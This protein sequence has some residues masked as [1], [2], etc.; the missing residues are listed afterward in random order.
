MIS[1]IRRLIHSKIGLGIAFILIALAAIAFAA[2][3]ITGGGG[4]LGSFTGNSGV[5]AKVGGTKLTSADLQNRTQMVFDRNRQQQPEMQ[6][7]GFLGMGGLENVLDQLIASLAFDEFARDQGMANSKRLIDG[8]I[9]SIDAFKDASGNFSEQMYHELLQRQRITD[10][11]LRQDIGRDL[12]NRQILTPVS[13]GSHM[14]R[15][16]VLPYAS[17]LMEARQGRI[18]VVPSR[19][20]LGA[21]A[22]NPQELAEF[23]RR[24]ADRYT[25]PEQRQLRYVLVEKA[26]FDKAAAPT[27]AEIQRYYTE[28]K[29][30]YAA[31]EQRTLEQLILPTEAAA[32]TIEAKVKGGTALVEAARSA[33]L[34]VATL[35]DLSQQQYAERSSQAVA[36]S[37]FA[38][39][40]GQIAPLAKSPLGWHLVRVAAVK[41][42]PA[43]ALDAVRAEVADALRQQKA[44]EAMSDFLAKAEDQ[45]T[46]GVTFDEFAKDSNLPVKATPLIVRSGVAPETP[47]YKAPPEVQPLLQSAFSMELD[48]E[49]QMVTIQPDILYALVDVTEIKPAAP[50]PLEKVRELVVQQ[51]QLDRA[52]ARAKTT[53]EQIVAKVNK[54]TDL[55]KAIGESGLKIPPPE[56]LG[57][58]RADI[59]RGGQQV[60][61]PLAMLFSM[62]EGSTKTLSAGNDQGWFIVRL[63]RIQRGD[64]GKQPALVTAVQ[65]EMG[66][67]IGNEYAEQFARAVQADV[68]VE[69][70]ANAIAGVKRQLRGGSVAQ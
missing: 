64:A 62:A 70:N 61:P 5:V 29:A 8:E 35:T 26:R 22:P 42:T 6:M 68:G 23:Y 30:N 53:A 45:M 31:R 41:A 54:G 57:G 20:F 13:S 16:M 44:A 52:S 1:L 60:P 56:S 17:L 19:L 67:V 38:T 58:K 2:G 25:I 12:F 10:A 28:N 18:A 33:G 43:R 36:R 24:N 37:A 63:D 9:A 48:D 7:S 49:P 51:F 3:D 32:R 11:A 66:R 4:G 65:R 59:A 55:A 39:P 21:D 14:S 40:Q 69:R 47:D 34:A 50:P 27:D 15:D 46:D